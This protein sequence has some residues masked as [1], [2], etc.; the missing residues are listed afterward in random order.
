MIRV[1]VCA[2]MLSGCAS[3]PRHPTIPVPDTY[4]EAC[5]RPDPSGVQTVGDL[6]SYSLKQDAS[7]KDCNAKRDGLVQIIDAANKAAKPKPWWR[8]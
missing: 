4:R 2:L 7:L 1:L 8:F 3:V 5:E 6:A